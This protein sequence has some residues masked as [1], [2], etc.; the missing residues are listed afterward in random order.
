MVTRMSISANSTDISQPVKISSILLFVFLCWL[1]FPSAVA[2]AVGQ[3]GQK[4]DSER[5]R[6]IRGLLTECTESARQAANL[7]AEQAI[8]IYGYVLKRLGGW[9]RPD[10]L[11]VFHDA[12]QKLLSIPGHATY[13]RDK[14]NAAKAAVRSGEMNW[15]DWSRLRSDCFQSL[16]HMPSEEAVAVLAEFVGDDFACMDS[17]N[18]AD[19]EID[20]LKGYAREWDMSVRLPAT[21]ALVKIGIE[22]P[23]SAVETHIGGGALR[24]AWLQWWQEVKEGKRKYRFK[25]SSVEHPINASPGTGRE[26]RRPER[27]PGDH[28]GPDATQKPASMTVEQ[29]HAAKPEREFP[30]W[31]LFAGIAIVLLIAAGYFLRRR[32]AG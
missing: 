31:Q 9:D 1:T 12:Q 30:R 26:V 8:P 20:G 29:Y 32:G 23:P 24:K 18:P 27:R 21:N 17:D 4:P 22:N 14:I 25:S 6:Q 19:Y 28:N 16:Q 13:Y 3:T 15:N 2:A 5:D 7:P 11:E 10:T